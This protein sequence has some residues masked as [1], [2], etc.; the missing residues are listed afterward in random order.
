MG[1][2]HILGIIQDGKVRLSQ[3]CQWDGYPKHA[4]ALTLEFCR[5]HLTTKEGREKFRK[6]VNLIH[7]LTDQEI[8]DIND[9]LKHD[10]TKKIPYHLTRDCSVAIFPIILNSTTQLDVAYCCHNGDAMW[11][12]EWQYWLD[13]DNGLLKCYAASDLIRS[14]RLDGLPEKDSFVKELEYLAYEEGDDE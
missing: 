14:Y 1:T 4:G 3:Y 12:I 7:Q 8:D 9:E 5:E 13:M 11:G 2:R 6:Q 10:S